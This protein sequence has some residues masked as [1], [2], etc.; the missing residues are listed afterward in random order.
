[1]PLVE[2]V[3]T[4]GLPAALR[5]VERFG[6]T[7]LPYLPPADKVKPDH[8]LVEVIGLEALRDICG[9]WPQERPYIPLAA[10]YLRDERDRELQ[11]DAAE[12]TVPQLARKY[13]ITERHVYRVLTRT[14]L[15]AT[16]PAAQPQR[17]LFE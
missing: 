17:Q 10:Q 8:P 15:A 11:R 16:D 2:L 9:L 13:E 5:L 14:D 3:K 6:G 1:M 4:L 12:L 7:R